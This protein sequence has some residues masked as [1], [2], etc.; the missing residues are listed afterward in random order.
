M[1]RLRAITSRDGV[2]V[3][4]NASSMLLSQFVNLLDDVRASAIKTAG[5]R[6]AAGF[7]HPHDALPTA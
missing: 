7:H 1:T 4:R 6:H 2:L 5:R 3:M